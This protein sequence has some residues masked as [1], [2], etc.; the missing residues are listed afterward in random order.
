MKTEVKEFL[1]A[2]STEVQA[3][4][5]ELRT[6]VLSVMPDALE[7]V[8]QPAKMLAYG[9]DATYK[10]MVC[11]IMPQK[12]WVNLGLPKGATMRDPDGLLEGTGKRARHVKVRSLEAAA[13]PGLRALIEESVRSLRQS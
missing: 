11:V 9:R 6:L 5:F 7:Q 3:I 13:A 1:S 12:T 10:G 2:Y 4:A 8:D